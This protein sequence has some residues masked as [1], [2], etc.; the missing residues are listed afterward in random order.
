[1]LNFSSKIRQRSLCD[2]LEAME[3]FVG[4][5]Y[6]VHDGNSTIRNLVHKVNATI[7]ANQT[8]NMSDIYLLAKLRNM[9]AQHLAD[10]DMASKICRIPK[11]QFIIDSDYLSKELNMAFLSNYVIYII[12][13]LRI[14]QKL[15]NLLKIK[16]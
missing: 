8:V 3:Y 4:N 7:Y 5:E 9:S 10:F 13:K 14:N 6:F 11:R 12:K 16:K 1:V 15:L 2:P